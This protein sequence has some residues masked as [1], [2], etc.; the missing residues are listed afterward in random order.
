MI[1]ADSFAALRHRN[2]RLIWIGLLVS[3]TGSMM[4]GAAVL[5]QVSL[6]VPPDKKGIALG[7]VGLV[8]VVPIVIFSLAS[9]VGADAWDRRKLMLFTQ[10][11]SALVS[12]VLAV[13]T[14]R[15]LSSPWPVYAL[16]AVASA[17]S[18][19]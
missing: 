11:G 9:G 5:W 3:F 10:V 15:G 13:L 7:L 17:V 12:L 16:S 14:L 19:F 2:F 1:S 4:Q 6:L 8:R 18:A